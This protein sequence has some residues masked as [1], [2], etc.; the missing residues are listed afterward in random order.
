MLICRD[1]TEAASGRIPPFFCSLHAPLW[2]GLV[3]KYSLS[4]RSDLALYC[5]NP[6]DGVQEWCRRLA[7]CQM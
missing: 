4:Q 7:L 5:L 3:G 2:V 1:R 6:P